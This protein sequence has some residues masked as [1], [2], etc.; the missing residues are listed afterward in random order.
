[1][2]VI[3]DKAD[4]LWKIPQP[5]LGDMQFARRRLESRGVNIIDLDRPLVD[6]IMPEPPVFLDRGGPAPVPTETFADLQARLISR[7][8]EKHYSLRGLGLDPQ[9]EIFITPGIRVAAGLITLGLLNPGESAAY[10]D[11]GPRHLR[12]AI[13]L[14][15][16]NP[17]KYGLLE[18]NDYIANIAGLKSAHSKRTKIIFV[19]YPH[20]PSGAAVDYYF[21]RELVRSLRFTNILIVADCAHVHPGNPDPAGPLQVKNSSRKSVELHSFGPTFGLLGLGFAAGHKD[22]ISIIAGLARALGIA[23]DYQAMR[24]ALALL[25]HSEEIFANRMDTLRRRREILVDGLKRLEWHVRSGRLAPF[26]WARPPVRSTS[27]AFARRLFVKAGIRVTPG[28]D[29][30]ENG[31]GWL[32]MTLSGDEVTM[33]EVVARLVQHSRIWQRKIGSEE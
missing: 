13:C 15:D 3:V 6:L 22:V 18:T 10:P 29:Y 27:L 23:P 28:S 24:I 11:P 9:K 31:E 32:R 26:V 30:G 14:A 16:A 12:T 2:R 7:I 25:D 17:R 5:S 8:L 21:Y 19:N 20:D 4:R 33:S 1:M